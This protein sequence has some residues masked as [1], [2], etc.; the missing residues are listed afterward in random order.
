[1]F[2]VAAIE[3]LFTCRLTQQELVAVVYRL[4]FLSSGA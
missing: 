3:S 4:F 2:A 1:M